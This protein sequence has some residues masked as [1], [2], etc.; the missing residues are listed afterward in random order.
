[1]V[2]PGIFI[3]GY[4]PGGLKGSIPEAN[5]DMCFGDEV[6]QKLKQFADIVYRF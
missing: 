5:P 4:S 3:W 2:G 1:M 6:P